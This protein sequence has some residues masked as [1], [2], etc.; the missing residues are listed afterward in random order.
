MATNGAMHFSVRSFGYALFNIREE[1]GRK[2]K[3]YLGAYIFGVLLSSII[4]GIIT[5]AIN[6]SHGREGGFWW[7]FWLWVIGVIIVAVRPSENNGVA[8][9]QAAITPYDELEKLA[10]LRNDG[11]LSEEEF[12]KLKA[13]LLTK[14]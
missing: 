8:V 10:K 14:M 3:M 12:A 6:K 2:R 1:L 5:Q 11:V 13:N 4:W 7:G 9:Q